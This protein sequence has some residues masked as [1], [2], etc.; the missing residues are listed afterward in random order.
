MQQ[1]TNCNTNETN[2]MKLLINKKQTKTIGIIMLF[3]D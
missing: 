2:E 1:A 3:N